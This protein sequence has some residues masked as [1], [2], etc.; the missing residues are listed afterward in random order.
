[1]SKVDGLVDIDHQLIRTVPPSVAEETVPGRTRDCPVN[2]A[3]SVQ[4]PKHVVKRGKT[5]VLTADQARTR[6]DQ[7]WFGDGRRLLAVV[8]DSIN[9]DSIRRPPRPLDHRLDVL[10]HMLAAR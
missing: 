3:S 4:G 1:M 7:L 9:T 5:P 2:P 8:L 6:T 10:H